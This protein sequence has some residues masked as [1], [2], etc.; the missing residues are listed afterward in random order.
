MVN[1]QSMIEEFDAQ[2]DILEDKFETF[3]KFFNESR[4]QLESVRK[5]RDLYEGGTLKV[6]KQKEPK[7]LRNRAYDLLK[8]VGHP[9][10][11]TQVH[12]ILDA[13]GVE[14]G[15]QSP[16]QNVIAHMSGDSRFE[17]KGNGLWGLSEWSEATPANSPAVTIHQP[18]T[19]PT[20]PTP[21]TSQTNP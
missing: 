11:Y 20:P 7:E 15:G 1:K 6:Q 4:E 16:P 17:T 13:M 9:L 19:Q 10:L 12:D 18:T 3:Q 14:I 8:G 5:T 2:I 21:I